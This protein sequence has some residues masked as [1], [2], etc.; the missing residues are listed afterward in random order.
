ME[1]FKR[2]FKI[3]ISILVLQ[4]I[5]T[6]S[7]NSLLAEDNRLSPKESKILKETF[8]YAEDFEARKLRIDKKAY[9]RHSNFES[10]FKFGFSGRKLVNWIQ[11]RIKSYSSGA[12]GDFIAYFQNGEVILGKQFFSLNKLDR[13][14][15]ILHEARHADGKEFT[16][17]NCPDDFLFLNPRDIR[18]SP[19]NKKA[20]DFRTDGSYGI[21]ASV[22]FEMGAYGY[23]SSQETAYRYNSEISRILPEE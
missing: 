17:V 1:E 5:S 13:F 10:I 11:T 18:I 15:T 14:L 12:T 6:L 2:N 16:H 19:A 3:T 20:C 21:T 7:A 8:K 23:L 9:L 4:L 22:L